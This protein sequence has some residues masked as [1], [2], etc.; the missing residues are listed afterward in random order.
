MNETS[1]TNALRGPGFADQYLKGRVLDIGC[2][3][4]IVC[5]WAQP[6]DVE[7]GDAQRISQLTWMLFLKI[8]DD[9]ETEY[10]LLDSSYKSPIA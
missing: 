10:E 8:F 1:K 3:T 5:A 4:D 7:H 9:K 6:F 2:G